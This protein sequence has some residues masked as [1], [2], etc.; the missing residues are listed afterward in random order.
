M[1]E[2]YNTAWQ[3]IQTGDYQLADVL[4]RIEVLYAA[5]RLTDEE[6]SG[7][8]E[9]ANANATPEAEL[10]ETQEQLEYLAGRLTALTGRVDAIEQ[11]LE[12]NGT[13]GT[14]GETEERSY[15]AWIQPIAGLTTDYQ[16][17]AIV[18]HNGKLWQNVLRNTQNVWEPGVVDSTFWIEYVP[19]SGE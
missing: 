16:Y 4:R 14:G 7:L 10:P 18:S 5:G 12:E 15:S 6:R 19:E 8:I 17:G 1:N 11:Q 2:I 13:A 9:A 3:M